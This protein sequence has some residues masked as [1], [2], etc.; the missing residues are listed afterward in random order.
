MAVHK[1]CQ[2]AIDLIKSELIMYTKSFT[3]LFI[4]LIRYIIYGNC[5]NQIHA[6]VG[7]MATS[8]S[9]S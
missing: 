4:N 7:K 9:F 6:S 3:V 1:N 5:I 2:H 8:Y